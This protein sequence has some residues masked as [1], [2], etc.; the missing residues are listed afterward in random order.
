MKI[1]KALLFGVISML[2][3]V[4]PAFADKK[5]ADPR[6][7]VYVEGSDYFVVVNSD[8]GRI[9]GEGFAVDEVVTENEGPQ[10]VQQSHESRPSILANVLLA[11]A[12]VLLSNA[13]AE[14][15]AIQD[16]VRVFGNVSNK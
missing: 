8:T 10:A 7:N 1:S 2:C 4:S 9:V 16:L 13:M 3:L 12:R 11:V 14:K 6:V 5:E 15:V